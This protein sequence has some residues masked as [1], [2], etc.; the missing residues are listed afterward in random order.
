MPEKESNMIADRIG[1]LSSVLEETSGYVGNLESALGPV[2]AQSVDALPAPPLLSSEMTSECAVHEQ[3]E[4]VLQ[5]AAAV[6]NSLL[7]LHARLRV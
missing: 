2:L 5:K 1:I 6:N 4:S 3:L 7:A